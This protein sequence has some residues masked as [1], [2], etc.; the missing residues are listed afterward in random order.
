MDDA[1]DELIAHLKRVTESRMR[2][3]PTLDSR[4]RQYFYYNQEGTKKEFDK[5][6]LKRAGWRIKFKDNSYIMMD[7]FARK[8]ILEVWDIRQI[9]FNRKKM[10]I[11]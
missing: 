5:F 2:N 7:K 11:N 6:Q 10:N 8:L 9:K 3:H 4:L 1:K